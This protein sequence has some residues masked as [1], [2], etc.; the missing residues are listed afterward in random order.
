MR[1]IKTSY[2]T[3]LKQSKTNHYN[4]YFESNWSSNRKTWKGLKFIL[5]IKN[6]STHIPKSLTVD[7][8]TVSNPM[9]ISNI[10]N[11]YFSSITSKRKHNI[12]FSHKLFS[13]FLK[14]RSNISIFVSQNRNREYHILIRF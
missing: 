14:N 5:T 4:H 13:D 8:T 11:N 7:G 3:I 12:S 9:A 1:N 10:F 2:T 6:I